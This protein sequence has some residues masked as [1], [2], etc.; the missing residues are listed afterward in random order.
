MLSVLYMQLLTIICKL[1]GGGSRV[2]EQSLQDGPIT[3]VQCGGGIIVQ[4]IYFVFFFALKTN[5]TKFLHTNRITE[6]YLDKDDGVF[7]PH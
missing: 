5:K 1:A 3:D 2:V 4:T 6:H 7:F